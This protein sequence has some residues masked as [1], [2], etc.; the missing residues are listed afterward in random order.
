[1]LYSSIDLSFDACIFNVLRHFLYNLL[2]KLFPL[3][4]AGVDLIHK[5]IEDFRLRIFQRKVIQLRLDLGI[6]SLC[7]IG[8]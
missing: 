6:P 2:H 7:A 8:A 4:F 5:V 1:M 3:C